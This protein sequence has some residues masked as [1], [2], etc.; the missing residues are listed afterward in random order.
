METLPDGVTAWES[1]GELYAAGRAVEV[2][3]TGVHGGWASRFDRASLT[4]DAVYFTNTM[5]TIMKSTILH[6][7]EGG[8]KNNN[9]GYYLDAASNTLMSAASRV[10]YAVSPDVL[11]VG[12]SRNHSPDTL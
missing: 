5:G 1:N 10:G 7:E 3:T 8:E 2:C 9:G 4:T 11:G 6:S 12:F